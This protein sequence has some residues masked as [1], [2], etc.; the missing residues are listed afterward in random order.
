MFLLAEADNSLSGYSNSMKITSTVPFSG[1]NSYYNFE[2][3]NNNLIGWN[4]N[5]GVASVTATNS[6]TGN[7]SVRSQ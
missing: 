2:A 6:I 5:G 7:Y 4:I 3:P 1:T